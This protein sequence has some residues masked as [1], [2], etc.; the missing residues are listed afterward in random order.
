MPDLLQDRD[1]GGHKDGQVARPEEPVLT[2]NW[3]PAIQD[4]PREQDTPWERWWGGTRDSDFPVPL[5][6]PWSDF[7][8]W[9]SVMGPGVAFLD[10]HNL[11]G[12]RS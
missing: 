6:S 5:V 3:V 10:G 8:F 2:C 11:G 7:L 12:L 1:I 9:R 4:S